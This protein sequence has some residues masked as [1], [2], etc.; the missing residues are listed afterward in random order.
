MKIAENPLPLTFGSLMESV[1]PAGLADL[2]TYLM[3]MYQPIQTAVN[4]GLEM[5]ENIGSPIAGTTSATAHASNVVSHTLGRIPKFLWVMAEAD[6]AVD[7]FPICFYWT[8]ADYSAWTTSQATFR[9]NQ[10]SI[11]YRGFIV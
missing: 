1:G 4:G 10:P 6:P 11:G 3:F 8:P 5:D 9:V 7:Q 2:Y